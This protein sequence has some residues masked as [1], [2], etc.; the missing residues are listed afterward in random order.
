MT[1]RRLW[2]AALV[3]AGFLSGGAVRSAEPHWPQALMLATA[4]PGGTYHAYGTG[5]ARILTRVLGVAVSMRETSGPSENIRLIEAGEAQIGF[6]TMGAALRAWTGT[7]E[8]QFRAMRA[9]FPMYDTPLHFVVRRDTPIRALAELGGRPIGVGPRDGTAAEYI[10]ALLARLGVAPQ[11]AYG[12]W[13]EL[14]A[15]LSN[16]SLQGLAVAAG[17][18][19]PAIAELEAQRAIR[20]LPLSREQILALRLATPELSASTIPP[21]T[22]PSLMAAYHTVGLYNFAVAHRDL[23]ADLVYA[24]VRAVFDFQ[25]ELM[26]AHPA[27]AATVPGNFVHNTVLPW[28]P[29]ASRYYG[30][31]SGAGVVTGD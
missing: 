22:Y 28:H 25:A 20:Y 19:F 21:G 17:V 7:G 10:P 27:A 13:A 3:V 9:I 14:T 11:F 15:Q 4:S 8:R 5:L 18:P 12:S 30:S 26:D 2:I 29:G 16:G 6:V 24:I 1:P 23:P 31:R